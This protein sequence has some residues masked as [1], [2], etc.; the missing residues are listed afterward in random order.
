[1][2]R[3]DF[4]LFIVMVA[5]ICMCPYTKVEE[6]FNLQATHDI[7]IYG[8][9]DISNY[10]HFEFP[11]VVPRT[12]IGSLVLALM[13]YPFKNLL[14]LLT[15]GVKQE[16]YDEI[17]GFLNKYIH[18]YYQNFPKTINPEIFQ[19]K[20]LLQYATRISLALLVVWSFSKLRKSVT[21]TWSKE[22][23]NFMIILTAV[24]F[25]IPFWGSRTLPNTFAL[26]LVNIALS[27]WVLK[28][29]RKKASN[30]ENRIY[31][32]TR[33]YLVI[34]ILTF[35]AV[36]F[37]IEIVLLALPIFLLE[38][39]NKKISF[40]R[41]IIVGLISTIISIGITVSIDS[42]FWGKLLWPEGSVFQFNVL[43]NG[44]LAYGTSPWYSYL[45]IHIPKMCALAI[46]FA[47]YA[48]Y[49]KPR[50]RRLLTPAIFYVI[51]YSFLPHKET[52]FIFYVV[53]IIN[54]AGGVGLYY[55]QTSSVFS[56][57]KKLIYY[58]TI[59]F[60]IANLIVSGLMA[61]VSSFN[62]PGGYALKAMNKLES[63]NK[64]IKIHIDV[65]TAQTGASRFGQINDKW[66]YDKDESLTT[67]QQFIDKG[68]NYAI[69]LQ[70]SFHNSNQWE[71]KASVNALSGITYSKDY[72]KIIKNVKA[73]ISEK[74]IKG[75]IPFKIHKNKK[76]YIIKRK[77]EQEK[78]II[79]EQM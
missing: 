49:E 40:V 4:F 36:V 25:Y 58:M 72:R 12:F 13:V 37:R 14:N 52:R 71:I 39:K 5:Y 73:C 26:I 60:V 23:G 20:F 31:E 69:V 16:T 15:F 18:P 44:S 66:I 45:S 24:Q 67:P 47:L 38:V 46:P 2:N 79:Q 74:E 10:D 28:T 29:T 64:E 61:Y 1:M 77:P 48:F 70:P 35:T 53:P 43:N 68:Y 7:L 59:L 50:I 11:G 19:N 6:S 56:V 34:F 63:R 33:S 51:V 57:T 62:Y 78:P 8:V 17:F 65:Y 21:K 76:V 55:I 32:K 30:R 22:A 3:W 54:I 27:F 41:L 9:K 75:C 42:Y